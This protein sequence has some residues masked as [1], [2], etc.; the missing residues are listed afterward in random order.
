MARYARFSFFAC[1]AATLCSAAAH[2]Y[3]PAQHYALVQAQDEIQLDGQLNEEVWQR[4]TQIDVNTQNE[5]LER[6]PSPVQTTAY[7]FED[8]RY[9]YLGIDAK[10]PN[11]RAIRGALRDRDELWQDDN[12]GI[13]I[14]SLNDER[15]AFEFFVNAYG[16]QGDILSTDFDTWITDPSW[17][18]TW[19]S[20]AHIYEGGYSVEMKIPLTVLNLPE[21]DEE[22]TWGISIARNYPRD[23]MYRISNVGFDLDIKCSFC[24]FDKLTGLS[25]R[26]EQRDLSVAPYVSAKRSDSKDPVP[27]PWQQGDTEVEVGAD[28]RWRVNDETLLNATINPDFSQVEADAVQ[29]D[30]N[31][32]YSL[33]YAEKR[34]FFLD[35]SSFFRTNQ[36]ELL[37]SR[38]I[39]EPDYGIKLSGKNGAHTYAGLVTDDNNASVLLPGNQGS[40]L[41]QL[42]DDV[43]NTVARYRYDL[44]QRSGLGVMLT[45]RQ[46]GD[47]HNTV[48]ALDGTY[49]LNA[50]DSINYAIAYADTENSAQ[51]ASGWQVDEQQSGTAVSLAVQRLKR[52]Y[53]LRAQYEQISEDFRADMGYQPKADYREV[54]LGGGQIWYGQEQD[55]LSKWGYDL[56][57]QKAYDLDGELLEQQYQGYVYGEGPWMSSFELGMWHSDELYYGEYFLQNNG[58]VVLSVRPLQDLTYQF[59]GDYGSRIDYSNARLGEGSDIENTLTWDANQHLQLQLSYNYSTLEVDNER[60]FTADQWDVR[61]YYKFNIRSMLKLIWQHEDV[62]R[63][64]QAYLYRQVHQRNRNFGSQLVYSYTINP[65]SVFY[66]GYS[67]S[68]YQN[69]DLD[70]LTRNERTFFTKISY[71]WQL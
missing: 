50:S 48:G 16:A 27:G 67:D 39:A 34:P 58:Y 7:L 70:S 68:G 54:E 61:L 44:G 13:V 14:D 45:H 6:A 9:L 20:G 18:A 8:G 69:D 56:E 60:V 40:S 46:G 21:T 33:Y 57:W 12:V 19:Y 66:L 11:P 71:A 62:D 23:V 31:T 41:A 65:Q 28:L 4:A 24:Q 43:T 26:H 63:N 10:D 36:L 52:D 32:N 25:E 3:P 2:A 55:W 17:D 51:F 59:Y 29:L 42:E 37:Y 38:T 30:V 5:P 22:I 1:A 53:E 47:Y 64:Q 49:G 15:N 35:G